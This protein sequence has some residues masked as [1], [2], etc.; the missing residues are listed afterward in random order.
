MHPTGGGKAMADPKVD[1]FVRA[2]EELYA[3]RL[4]PILEPAHI[5]EFV[6]IEP[7]S[8]EYVLGKTLSE[9]TRLARKQFPHRLTHVMRV[10]HSA[11]LHFGMHVR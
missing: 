7:E 10:G 2:A 4:R 3:L 11:A 9:A 8:G 6:A 1:E 5:D